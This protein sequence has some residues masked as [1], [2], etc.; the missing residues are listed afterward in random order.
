[1]KIMRLSSLSGL[2]F[3]MFLTLS[4]V[5]HA[6]IKLD[7]QP[8]NG[9]EN[10]FL[11]AECRL[12][13]GRLLC[14]EMTT[15]KANGAKP[16][17]RWFSNIKAEP[18]VSLNQTEVIEN[19]ADPAYVAIAVVPDEGRSLTVYDYQ[20]ECFGKLYR[21][22]GLS[23]NWEPQNVRVQKM[24]ETRVY[25]M[26]FVIEY[27]GYNNPQVPM[28][29]IWKLDPKNEEKTV[30]SVVNCKDAPL[31]PI[32]KLVR[33]KDDY[34]KILSG[35]KVLDS[36]PPS[37]AVYFQNVNG[38]EVVDA[39]GRP[40]GLLVSGAKTVD[41]GISGKCLDL[42]SGY[43]QIN[44]GKVIYGKSN[45]GADFSI[46]LWIKMP[47]QMRTQN[48]SIY[49]HGAPDEGAGS[50]N[51]KLK[52]GQLIGKVNAVSTVSDNS[53]MTIP[54]DAVADDQWHMIALTVSR[55]K[56]HKLYFDGVENASRAVKREIMPSINAPL[57]LGMN[58]RL[59]ANSKFKGQIDRF[60]IYDST[61]DPAEISRLAKSVKR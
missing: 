59:A 26:Y 7:A 6:Q 8:A 5:L 47:E 9:R 57:I 36:I 54:A 55:E 41:G 46:V 51:F 37:V 34:V 3:M 20:L 16:F 14:A 11:S 25:T 24:R 53:A 50:V 39:E 23:E 21:C 56:G 35:E 42:T 61:L 19:I 33:Q 17:I 18:K 10:P 58:S 40:I 43:A 32:Q 38:S 4:A 12:R 29:L 1:M 45:L 22:V 30:V 15:G 31:T 28:S 49:A 44:P 13:I 60:M 48:V 27:P 52:D 2:L